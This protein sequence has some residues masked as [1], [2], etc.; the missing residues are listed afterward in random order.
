MSVAQKLT[1]HFVLPSLSDPADVVIVLLSDAISH[2]GANV[3]QDRRSYVVRHGKIVRVAGCAHPA[4]WAEAQREN[5]AVAKQK[6]G[7]H[8]QVTARRK[9]LI[10]VFWSVFFQE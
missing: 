10:T 6:E 1:D 3:L 9:D 5:V 7:D 4:K 8:K 2:S